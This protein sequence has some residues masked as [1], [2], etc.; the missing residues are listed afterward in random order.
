MF[1]MEILKVDDK[2]FQTQMLGP[3]RFEC[4]AKQ[5]SSLFTDQKKHLQKMRFNI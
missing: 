2:I 1:S 3:F 4:Y 5:G